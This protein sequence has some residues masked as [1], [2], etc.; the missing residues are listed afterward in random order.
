MTDADKNASTLF[1]DRSDRHP[2]PDW[3]EN[4][5]LNRGLLLVEISALAEVCTLWALLLL[6]LL[7]GTCFIC[8]HW[9]CH[10]LVVPWTWVR[11]IYRLQRYILSRCNSGKRQ[12]QTI[13]LLLFLAYRVALKWG[14]L[15]ISR[16]F[17]TPNQFSRLLLT[18]NQQN[19]PFY[20]FNYLFISRQC[21]NRTNQSWIFGPP[22]TYDRN[23]VWSYRYSIIVGFNCCKFV[24]S[25]TRHLCL[26][27]ARR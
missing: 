21:K 26:P 3:S 4:P 14:H 27:A 13:T 16:V 15:L 20:S 2:D 19:W 17:E 11:C 23:S 6:L 12:S 7:F 5:E 18:T 10:A 1:W 8:Q 22:R 9:R 25:T 24:L